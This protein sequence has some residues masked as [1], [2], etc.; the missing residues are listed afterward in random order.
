MLYDNLIKAFTEMSEQVF[1]DNLV[2][3][4]LHGS[5]AMG[6]FNPVKS[7][8]DILIIINKDISDEEKMIF[9][10]NVIDLD[11]NATKNGF[12]LSIVKKEFCNPFVYPTSFELHFSHMHIDW[13][14]KDPN[15]YIK[16]MKGCDNDL[17]AH[18][19]IVNKYGI[20]LYGRPIHEVF[21]DVPRR[22]YF[23]SIWLDIENS[24]E[25]ILTNPMYIT[26]NL[27]RVLAYAK[28]NLILSKKDGGEWGIGNL[29][30]KYKYIIE[31]AL[32]CYSTEEIMS[33]DK[34][35]A[36]DYTNYMMEQIK[37]YK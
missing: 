30:Q 3:V 36:L 25:D 20:V 24:A 26:L 32:R 9:M 5:L 21:G 12:E 23:D 8:L 34:L 17:A 6:C 31:D 16:K 22:D 14:K 1:K 27:C 28:E 10:K 29:P 7:D 13:F 37:K 18:F 15:D 19:T 11:K 35:V 4:Y 2:G 33:I